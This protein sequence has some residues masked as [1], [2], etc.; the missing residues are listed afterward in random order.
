MVTPYHGGVTLAPMGAEPRIMPGE[1][2][3]A[4]GGVEEF[5]HL[6]EHVSEG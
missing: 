5:F 1:A 6:R 2:S 4:V 3:R